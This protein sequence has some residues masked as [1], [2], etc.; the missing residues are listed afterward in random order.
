MP[1]IYYN[2]NASKEGKG[3]LT[4]AI[5]TMPFESANF[6]K[7]DSFENDRFSEVINN[8]NSVV[9]FTTIDKC[10][11]VII[12]YKWCGYDE[13][14]TSLIGEAKK[15]NKKVIA[16]FNDD[17]YPSQPLKE[18]DGYMFLTTFNKSNKL[19]NQKS[20]PAFCGDF[21][22]KDTFSSNKNYKT[23]GFC[24]GITHPVRVDTLK[25]LYPSSVLKANFIIRKGF[26][27]PEISDRMVARE[28]YM[29]HL[30]DNC[31]NVCMRGAGN[32]SYRLYET[33]M[34][35]RIPIIIDSDQVFP[36]ENLLDYNEFSIMVRVG[37]LQNINNIISKWLSDKTD[38]DIENIQK[39]NR[40]LW[41]TYMSPQGWLNN[42]IK[43][44]E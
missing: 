23:V 16:L 5:F 8:G 13:L 31:F 24:G 14:T 35:G 29:K 37:E 30:Q 4:E 43:E 17:N 42:F 9:E 44:L 38:Q 11:Y 26:W 1:K 12:P 22:K 40:E 3:G 10:D 25:L 2:K 28:E 19:T 21:Y 27:A 7:E 34:M 15:Y 41:V 18:E 6:F 32:F 39:R 33:M 20:F 36:F